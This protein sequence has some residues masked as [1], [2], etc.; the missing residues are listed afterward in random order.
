MK[1]WQRITILSIVAILLIAFGGL[2][3]KTNGEAHSLITSPMATRDLP[4]E[5]P[6]KYNM[7]Y[8]DV[9]ITS[10]DGLKLA[11]WFVPSQ[12]G[13]VIIMQHGYKSTRDEMLNEAE[14]MYRHGYGALITSIRAHDTAK[15]KRSHSA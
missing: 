11:G 9:T 13:A 8:E 7:P 6:A 12:N 10:P 5:T 2:L 15:V 1:R 3:W 4:V 14:M